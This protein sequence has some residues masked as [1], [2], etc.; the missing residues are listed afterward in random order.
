MIGLLST[1]TERADNMVF[2]VGLWHTAAHLGSLATVRGIGT[3]FRSPGIVRF[4]SGGVVK[5]FR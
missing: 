5:T 3:I 4:F 2:T 1:A